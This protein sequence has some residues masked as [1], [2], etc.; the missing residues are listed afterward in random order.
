MAKS[1]YGAVGSRSAF[2]TA[3]GPR[4]VK[5][6]SVWIATPSNMLVVAKRFVL[7]GLTLLMIIARGGVKRNATGYNLP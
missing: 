7:F 6:T 1:K 4:E 5:A 2:R 3:R